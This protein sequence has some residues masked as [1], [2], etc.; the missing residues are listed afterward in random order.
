MNQLLLF[1]QV[2]EIVFLF[3]INDGCAKSC[4]Y[5]L[6]ELLQRKI[7]ALP[8]DA[9]WFVAFPLILCSHSHLYCHLSEDLGMP[10]LLGVQLGTA[11]LGSPPVLLTLSSSFSFH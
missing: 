10:P 9:F 4:C 6:V 3:L 8:Y 7:L 5:F 1:G 2:P 11:L